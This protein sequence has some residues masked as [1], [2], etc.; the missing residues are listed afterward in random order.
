M[1]VKVISDII[2]K[3]FFPN[4]LNISKLTLPHLLVG[5]TPSESCNL[6]ERE[7][8]LIENLIFV[9]QTAEKQYCSPRN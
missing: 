5:K 7:H 1:N 2:N 4:N 8:I 3:N 9:Y 6:I